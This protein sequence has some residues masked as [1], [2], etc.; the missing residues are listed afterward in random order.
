[1]KLEVRDIEYFAAVASHGNVGRAAEQLGMSQPALS[2]SLRRL[3]AGIGAKLVKRTPKGVDLTAV[4][5][6]LFARAR[7]LRL[8]LDDIAREAMELSR[9]QTGHLRIGAGSV[10]AF[11]LVPM[12]CSALRK[13]TSKVTVSLTTAQPDLLTAGIRNG[14][15]IWLLPRFRRHIIQI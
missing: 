15:W 13:D 7:G 2:K 3:E 14:R 10:F 5:A 12:T 4:G 9:G 6:A 8:S 11:H 1:M